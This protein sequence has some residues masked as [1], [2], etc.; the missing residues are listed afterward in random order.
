MNR[1]PFLNPAIEISD[2]SLN[3]SLLKHDFRNPY[4]ICFY[5]DIISVDSTPWKVS[6]VLIVPF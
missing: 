4:S 1:G 3:P 5:I 6:F 2:N